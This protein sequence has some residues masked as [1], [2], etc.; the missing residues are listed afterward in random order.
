[1]SGHERIARQIADCLEDNLHKYGWD[2]YRHPNGEHKGVGLTVREDHSRVHLYT[3]PCGSP[4]F[5]LTIWDMAP[6]LK[7]A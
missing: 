2:P 3:A 5:E 4:M 7:A 6:G 1:M